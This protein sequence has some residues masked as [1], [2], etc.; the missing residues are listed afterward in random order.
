MKV[1]YNWL[2]EF[3]DLKIAPRQLAEKLTMAGLEVTALEERGGDFVF[4][5]EITSNR[6]DWLS[7]FGVAREVA[8]I[9][10]KKLKPPLIKNPKPLPARQA[11]KNQDLAKVSIRV[12]NKKDCPLYTAKI[13]RGVKVDPSPEWLR[14]RL[15]SV[16][17]R[18]VNN[19]V[20]I[21]NYVLFEQGEPL[22]AFDLDKISGGV[23]AVRRARDNEKIT[24]IDGTQRM[25]SAQMLVIADKDKPIAIA[26]VMGGGESE[27]TPATRNLL[28]EAA[29][30][31]PIAVRLGRQKLA[32]QSESSYRFERGVDL[33]TVVS[34]SQ[35]AVKLILDLC[36]GELVAAVTSGSAKVKTESI[37][38]DL[39][40]SNSMLGVDIPPA[41][42]GNILK[43][44]GFKSRP[45]G[46]MKL[47][48][49]VPAFR[50]DVTSEV[51][52]TEEL[53]RIYGYE[54]IPVTV[55]RVMPVILPAA[56][57]D[58]AGKIRSILIGLG[59]D[60][61]V[62]YSLVD[63]NSAAGLLADA[64]LEVANPLSKEQAVLRTTLIPGLLKSVATNLNQKQQYVNIFEIAN[65][66]SFTAS[67]HREEL[68]LG[69]ALCGVKPNF[70]AEQGVIKEEASM[71]HIKGA[72]ETL[73]H[74]L[75]LGNYA[76]RQAG[77]GFEVVFGTEALG[78][79]IEISSAILGRFEIKGRRVFAAEL[80][81]AKIFKLAVIN[82]K[83][84]PLPL[85]PSIAR[86]VS[87]LVKEGIPAADILQ[88]AAGEAGALLEDARVIDY[89]K[90]KQIPAGLKSLTISCV[91]RSQERTLTE[92]EINP[93]HASL[94][95]RLK[96]KFGAQLR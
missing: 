37:A 56:D 53:A 54:K 19:L 59:L 69:I 12:E 9:T 35:R 85:Y 3:V 66:F 32:L 67:G 7:V 33:Q 87:F 89:Y 50:Q 65:V 15:E 24:T 63:N 11:G 48:V 62:T 75:G 25:L 61:A 44:L 74:R 70:I 26:G 52:L 73:F 76:F 47:G 84:K 29:V 57:R 88:A 46:R 95:A 14:K 40:A 42:A 5:I 68:C 71:M 83:F 81:L 49:C 58:F 36:G 72:L 21:T 38:F 39:A 23:I 43:A 1:T 13:I 6:P 28:L 86:D 91:Y 41:K 27:V 20:D 94:V 90:G 8:A 22:H 77:G 79:A 18:S 45:A 64:P 30:F 16:G 51:D 17:C 93:V 96:S 78:R 2:K 82:K 4:E 55:P 34:A 60:E 80:N 92:E 31:D 10:G